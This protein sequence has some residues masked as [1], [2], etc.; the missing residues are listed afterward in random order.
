M[1]SGTNLR[2][3]DV[4]ESQTSFDIL[5]FFVEDKRKTR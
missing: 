1:S 5:G 4:R 3:E 2:T